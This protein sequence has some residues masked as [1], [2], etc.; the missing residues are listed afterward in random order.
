[1]EEFNIY[2]ES[3]LRGPAIRAAAGMWLIEHTKADGNIETKDGI[4]YREKIKET[5]LVLQCMI[6]AFF[7]LNRTGIKSGSVR[8]FT[9]CTHVLNTINNHWLPM[10]EKNGWTNAKGK[11]AANKELW[12]QLSALMRNYAVSVTDE[13]HSYRE[14]YMR[15]AIRKELERNNNV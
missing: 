12:Q 6:N 14:R 5:E 2:I 8:V 7:I 10:W 11:P 15:E 13:G 4:L 3:S 1:M 9:E